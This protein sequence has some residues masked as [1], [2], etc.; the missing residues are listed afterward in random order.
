MKKILYTVFAVVFLSLTACS[1]DDE[2][3]QTN[4]SIVGSWK[5]ISYVTTNTETGTI[6]DDLAPCETSEIYTFEPLS[7]NGKGTFK[8]TPFDYNDVTNNC[9]QQSAVFSEW[10]KST[11]QESIYI[12]TNNSDQVVFEVQ[13]IESGSK[14][15]RTVIENYY[16]TVTTFQ[17]Q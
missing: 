11:V 2:N 6:W 16:V 3:V 10:Q 15:K 5:V 1:S 17:R 9:V 7:S 12:L 4:D 13:F 14:M 8:Y